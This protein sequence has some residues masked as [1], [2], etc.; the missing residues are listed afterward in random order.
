MPWFK[1]DDTLYSHPKWV[2]APLSARGLWTSAGSWCASHLQDGFVP[3]HALALFGAR[4]RDATELVRVG[5]WDEVDGGWMFH[6]WLDLQP[7]RE[8]V[9]ALRRSGAARQKVARSP[10]LRTAV[11]ERDGDRCRYCGVGVRWNDRRGPLGGTYDHVDPEG[12]SDFD[13]LV[14]CCRGCNASKG[15]R[16]PQEAGMRLLP[17]P[18]PKSDL[19]RDPG[20]DLGATRPPTRPDPTRPSDVDTPA[21]ANG[22]TPARRQRLI[23][24][25]CR[26]LAN[27]RAQ[28]R[29]DVGPGWAPACARGL[30]KDH[31]QAL[32]AHLAAHPDATASDLVD[33]MDDPR[34]TRRP[35][36]PNP[37]SQLRPVADVLA[38]FPERDDKLN[39]TAIAA[40]RRQMHPT[41]HSAT[42]EPW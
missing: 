23:D 18:G 37:S 16:T 6:D 38:S 19:D 41:T 24:E 27:E 4:A 12:P 9:L 36:P 29:D 15:R 2:A 28:A 42:D 21:A 17:P 5:L 32:H 33:L 7:S 3:R 10:E 14:V 20:S 8:D 1:V 13:N 40:L 39:G 25:A 26:E 35:E 11:R 30:A 34:P 31:H 22:T